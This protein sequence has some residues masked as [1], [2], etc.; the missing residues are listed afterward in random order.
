MCPAL[1]FATGDC[2]CTNP[3]GTFVPIMQQL[4]FPLEIL[5][6]FIGRWEMSVHE[7]DHDVDQIL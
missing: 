4:Q 1:G 7:W 2:A 6:T 5:L 3:P